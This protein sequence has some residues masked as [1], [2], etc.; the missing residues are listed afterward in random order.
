MK[1]VLTAGAPVHPP[2]RRGERRFCSPPTEGP[3]VRSRSGA[4]FVRSRQLRS[5]ALRSSRASQ[6]ARFQPAESR[7]PIPASPSTMGRIERGRAGG[8]AWR[9]GVDI[10]GTFTDV[11][12]IDDATGQHRRRQGAHHAAR[13]RGRRA[14]ARCEMAMQRYEAWPPPTS[15]CCR[16]PPP[17]S[18]T[19]SSRRRAPAPPSSPRAAFATCW[20]CAARRARIS[21]TCSRMRRPR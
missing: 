3:D 16:M 13:L 10:G 2:G 15:G 1:K 20:S 6:P 4:A 18:P 17:S 9:I 8:M 7:V 12:L 19:P 21:T 11:A 5:A 14:V